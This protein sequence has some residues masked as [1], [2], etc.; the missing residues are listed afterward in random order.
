MSIIES[1][2][3]PSPAP[4]GLL[5]IMGYRRNIMGGKD[6]HVLDSDFVVRINYLDN[7]RG[8][9]GGVIIQAMYILT[10]AHCV[11]NHLNNPGNLKVGLTYN[12]NL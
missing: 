10:A 11:Y 4:R 8:Q 3:L 7:A 5:D 2:P 6:A 12:R 9:C 1:G